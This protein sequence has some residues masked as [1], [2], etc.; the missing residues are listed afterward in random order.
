MLVVKSGAACYLIQNLEHMWTTLRVH[1]I[2]CKQ[3]TLLTEWD[4][5]NT[6]IG[7]TSY[8]KHCVT[9]QRCTISPLFIGIFDICGYAIDFNDLLLQVCI[10][11]IKQHCK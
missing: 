3:L 7:N 6:Q 2:D 1:V 10:F 5:E 8:T 4:I 9:Q 11:V